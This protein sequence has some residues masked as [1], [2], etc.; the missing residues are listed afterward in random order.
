M[1]KVLVVEDEEGVRK[2]LID[3]FETIGYQTFS[4]SNAK[5]AMDIFNKERPEAIFLDI[6]LPDKN[7]IELLKEIK[8]ISTDNIVV[9]VSSNTDKAT[10]KQALGAGAVEF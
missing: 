8:S 9:M 3:T 7:G 6:M 2:T 1:I 10:K 4:A 5:E